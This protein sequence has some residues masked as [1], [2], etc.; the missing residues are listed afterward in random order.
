MDLKKDDNLK[1]PYRHFD[2]ICLDLKKALAGVERFQRRL[3]PFE[4]SGSKED[5]L[6][7]RESLK[8]AR[9]KVLDTAVP[10]ELSE[11]TG[12]LNDSAS[13]VLDSLETILN[14][15]TADFQETFFQVMRARRKICQAQEKLY[16]LRLTFPL[17]NRLFMETEVYD[18]VDEPDPKP[19]EGFLVDLNHFGVEDDNYSRGAVSLYVPEYYD[20]QKKWPVVVALHGGSGHGRDFIWTWLREA[21]S[22]GFILLSPTSK[23]RTWSINDP[24]IDGNALNSMIEYFK[25]HY[26]FDS[27]K[28][29]LTGISDGA[30]FA[31]EWSL[32]PHSPFTA[33]ATIAG[34]LPQMDLSSARGRRI[35]MIHGALDWLFH[36]ERSQSA[37]D[38]LK[39][40]GADISLRVIDDLSHTYPHEENRNIL[41]WFEPGLT[42]PGQ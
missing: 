19:P 22:R 26:N 14:A 30:T 25:E 23:D 37:F 36:V 17:L 39:E 11:K 27:D 7:L 29:L 12:I 20:N 34:V 5:L 42:L 8:Q 38:A 41:K 21:R 33:F 32:Q 4:F 28:I 3:S 1:F 2:P 31:L 18:R 16:P 24:E 6:P 15:S 13:L 10:A 35:Y 40:A 9:Q